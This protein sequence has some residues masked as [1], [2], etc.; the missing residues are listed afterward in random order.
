MTNHEQYHL[1]DQDIKDM[2]WGNVDSDWTSFY[3]YLSER[4]LFIFFH[5]SFCK[6]YKKFFELSYRLEH[7]I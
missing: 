4:R 2:S 3:E 1:L 5:E 7:H 6:I